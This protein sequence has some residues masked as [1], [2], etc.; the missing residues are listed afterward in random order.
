MT[1][2]ALLLV[3]GLSIL[4]TGCR[5]DVGTEVAVDGRGGGDVALTVRIDGATLREL[6]RM[7]ADPGLDVELS[8][9][10]DARWTST[11][12]IDADGGLVLT[13]AQSFADGAEATALLRELSEGVAP[14]DPAIRLDV[15]M[16]TTSRGGV[17][18]DGLG[19]ITAPA[20]LGVSIDDQVVGPTGEELAA[21]VEDAVRAEL[22]VRVAG[23][24]IADDA[25]VSDA[26]VARWM[27]PVGTQRP[28]TLAA[29]GP[30]LFA[31][32]PWWAWPLGVFV[33]AGAMGLLRRGRPVRDTQGD[34][35]A[36]VS[37]AG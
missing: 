5:L 36:A 4:L 9:G 34:T 37:P 2:R 3:A 10:Q 19:G 8:L 27:L 16:V 28:I 15:T 6:D 35:G 13:Y 23:R 21:L 7:G 31:R 1:V 17:R 18:I 24:I 22:V 11:R 26:Q 30:G 25:D 20:T 12:R 33:I 32:I 29:D 14:Q